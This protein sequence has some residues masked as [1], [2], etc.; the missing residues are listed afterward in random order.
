MGDGQLDI[1][2]NHGMH[3]EGRGITLDFI[4]RSFTGSRR[5]READIEILDSTDLDRFI[6]LSHS[7]NSYVQ[8]ID[9][10]TINIIKIGK[11]SGGGRVSMF[12]CKIYSSFS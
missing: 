10:V 11:K 12:Y 8:I 6:H 9:G 5:F 4:V 2:I 1:R 7:D 3:I